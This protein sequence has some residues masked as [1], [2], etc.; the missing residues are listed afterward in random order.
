M[1]NAFQRQNQREK[2]NIKQYLEGWRK[3]RSVTYAFFTAKFGKCPNKP[4]LFKIAQFVA[5]MA[6]IPGVN[7]SA[8]RYKN[9]C[10]KWFD[11]HF[12]IL[13]PF[14]ENLFL[15][16]PQP[17]SIA[18]VSSQNYDL[19][20][21]QNPPLFILPSLK[22]SSFLSLPPLKDSSFSSLPPLESE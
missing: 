22:A 16:K 12:L 1:L 21:A 4:D 2:A 15:S 10:L 9:V 6:Q 7:R 18:L 14:L 3:E 13:R 19:S 5:L 8:Q 11:D 20:N 17:P